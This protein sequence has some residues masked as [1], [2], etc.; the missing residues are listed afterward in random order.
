M[1]VELLS[2]MVGAG[3]LLVIL[4]W[5]ILIV[6]RDECNSCQVITLMS[7]TV[8]CIGVIT[9]LIVSSSYQ[10]EVESV[11]TYPIQIAD[12]SNGFSIQYIVVNGRIVN[13]NAVTGFYV[14]KDAKIRITEY[15]KQYFGVSYFVKTLYEVE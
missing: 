4:F 1:P 12:N 10:I 6:N 2:F 11:K 3:T 13:I 15:K 5:V 14:N 9:W 8:V 7:A